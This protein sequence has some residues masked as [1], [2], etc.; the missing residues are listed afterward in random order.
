MAKSAGGVRGSG[1][2]PGTSAHDKIMSVIEDIQK[3]GFSK[4]SP[5]TVGKVETALKEYAAQHG[6]EIGNGQLYMSPKQ[7]AHTL[8]DLHADKGID[9]SPQQLASFPARRSNMNLYHDSNGDK[10][11]YFD[12]SV[13]YVVHPNYNLKLPSGKQRVVN[14]ITAYTSNGSEFNQQNFTKIR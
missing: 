5:F 6:I 11:I 1:G 14:F 13:K 9:I 2:S 12:G 3:N 7:I 4:Q 10:F 8:R